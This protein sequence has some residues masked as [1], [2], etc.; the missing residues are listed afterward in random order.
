[1]TLSAAKLGPLMRF[2]R[3]RISG[4]YIFLEKRRGNHVNHL[5]DC[6]YEWLKGFLKPISDAYFYLPVDMQEYVVAANEL[7]LREDLP[8]PPGFHATTQF[9]ITPNFVTSHGAPHHADGPSR[10]TRTRCLVHGR[11]VHST[12][13][14]RK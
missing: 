10:G 4:S 5:E 14:R 8:Y 1:M 6:A 2:R 11:S 9:L 12:D 7:F 3:L 13:Q